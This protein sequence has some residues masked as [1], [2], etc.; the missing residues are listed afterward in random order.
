VLRTRRCFPE[1]SVLSSYHL[2]AKASRPHFTSLEPRISPPRVLLG[3]GITA[4]LY[5][6]TA[7]FKSPIRTEVYTDSWAYIHTV[8]NAVHV[9]LIIRAFIRVSAYPRFYF[10]I[11]RSIS[12][13]SSATVEVAALA[14][15]VASAVSL[16]R[17]TVLTPRT[18][19]QAFSWRIT[20]KIH[21][22]VIRSLFYAFSINAAICRKATPRV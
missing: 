16:T 20:Q 3:H 11:M 12:I 10:S 7:R 8:L 5:F 13:L 1:T 4:R 19:N 9:T 22:H 17:P 6:F 15:T 18:T 21:G 2:M 14:H